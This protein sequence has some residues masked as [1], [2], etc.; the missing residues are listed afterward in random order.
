TGLERRDA[1]TEHPARRAAALAR[2][3]D[4]TQCRRS[5]ATGALSPASQ[6]GAI[7][8]ARLCNA[9]ARCNLSV[10]GWSV[11]HASGD[12][13]VSVRRDRSQRRYSARL[14]GTAVARTGRVFRISRLYLG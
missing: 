10:A 8:L 1:P 12:R 7:A 5:P 3:S 13:I 11:L 4:E 2:R 9:C 14:C 6:C